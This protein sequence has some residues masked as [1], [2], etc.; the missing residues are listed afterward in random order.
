MLVSSI[1]WRKIVKKLISEGASEETVDSLCDLID[2][3]SIEN[4]E[5]REKLINIKGIVETLKIEE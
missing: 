2:S 5:L 1:E 3:V 4:K